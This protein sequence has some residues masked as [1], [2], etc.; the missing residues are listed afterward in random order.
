[1]YDTISLIA[2]V[3]RDGTA[4][5]KVQTVHFVHDVSSSARHCDWIVEWIVLIC[6]NTSFHRRKEHIIS[7]GSGFIV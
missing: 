2:I 6:L 3:E 4:I 1:M 5:G 7:G